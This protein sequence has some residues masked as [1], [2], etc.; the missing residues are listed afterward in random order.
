MYVVHHP[1]CLKIKEYSVILDG[2]QHVVFIERTIQRGK[3][4][5]I[6]WDRGEPCYPMSCVI[7]IY[8]W[9][10]VSFYE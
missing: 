8:Y 9:H 6:S 4:V 3:S 1:S 5:T 2:K 10:L 7:T